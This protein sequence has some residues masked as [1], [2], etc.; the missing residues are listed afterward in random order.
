MNSDGGVLRK[1]CEDLLGL[2]RTEI[3]GNDVDLTLGRLTVEDLCQEIDV[4]P[5][6][7]TDLD[8]NAISRRKAKC[9]GC[10][11]RYGV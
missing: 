1:K 10:G 9:N 2:V 4:N 11:Y 8:E 3:I 6:Q 5:T 7:P